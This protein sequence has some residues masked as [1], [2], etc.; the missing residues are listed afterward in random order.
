MPCN[1][2]VWVLSWRCAI[3]YFLHTWN[4]HF[5][6]FDSLSRA[7]VAWTIYL[8]GCWISSSSIWCYPVEIHSLYS[9]KI[10]KSTEFCLKQFQHVVEIVSKTTKNKTISENIKRYNYVKH[11]SCY[12]KKNSNCTAHISIST[13]E[14]L[15]RIPTQ[16]FY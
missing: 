5:Y 11:I 2:C 1:E 4:E 3:C 7:A 10:V 13:A 8:T 16:C 12:C 6:T 14:K 9:R 15:P